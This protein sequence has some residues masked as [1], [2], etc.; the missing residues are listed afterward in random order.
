ME[1]EK[2]NMENNEQAALSWRGRGQVQVTQCER[3]VVVEIYVSN[4]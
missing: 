4:V 1:I 2:I 3:P